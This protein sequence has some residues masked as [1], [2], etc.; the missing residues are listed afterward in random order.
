MPVLEA[1]ACGAP[2]VCSNAASL[3]EVAGDAA[4][5]V[6]PGDVA[7][8]AGALE[9][10]V[11]DEALRRDLAARGFAQAARFSWDETARRTLAVYQS[12]A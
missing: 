12:L 4:L 8:L 9:R 5:L 1:M 11:S 10:V 7:A 6:P 3:P 2:V